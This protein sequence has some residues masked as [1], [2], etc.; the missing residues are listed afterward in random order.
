MYPLNR[1]GFFHREA[2]HTQRLG[3]RDWANEV[4]MM[5]RWRYDKVM[6]RWRLGDGMIWC[7]VILYDLT[8]RKNLWWFILDFHLLLNYTAYNCCFI[9]VYFI[10]VLCVL[11][12]FEYLL[13]ITLSLVCMLLRILQSFYTGRQEEFSELWYCP[14]VIFIDKTTTSSLIL[15]YVTVARL[16]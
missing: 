7:D 16:G 6:A 9:V 1:H 12:T 2:I 5:M 15:T 13:S 8:Y 3:P 11:V 14:F 10:E 4:M